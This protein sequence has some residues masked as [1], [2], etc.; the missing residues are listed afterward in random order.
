MNL[1]VQ[2]DA[3]AVTGAG[4][5]MRCA[6]LG[7]AWIELGIGRVA[8]SGTIS[9]PFAR[10]R[11]RALGIESCGDDRLHDAD[12]LVL[13]TY[14]NKMRRAGAK[15]RSRLKVLVDDLGDFTP[16]FDVIWN[17]NA[18]ESAQMYPSFTGRVISRQ[19]PIRRGLPQWDPESTSVAVSLGGS[20]PPE[21]V[22]TAIDGWATQRG[23]RPVTGKAAWMP[24]G[25]E[26][27]T[28]DDPWKVFSK[29][30][31]MLTAGGSTVW[32]AAFVGIPTCVLV[33]SPN[34]RFIGDWAKSNG[35]PV[36]DVTAEDARGTLS[37][38][39]GA[40]ASKAAPLPRIES[41]AAEVA[42]ILHG[43]AAR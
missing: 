8:H 13:D 27:V 1:I 23:V 41:G 4:H 25:W 22:V 21:W 7:E 28:A 39:L 38:R 6:S 31:M 30:A 16:G 36:I 37:L 19:V 15:G 14:D 20:T 42:T 9:I 33:T 43:L 5:V 34:Q 3:T 17:P 10:N 32:E 12:V 35:V 26:V 18:Y 40:C 11:L 24:S 2:A 29:S